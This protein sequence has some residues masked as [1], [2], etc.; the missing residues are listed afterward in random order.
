MEAFPKDKH[1]ITVIWE[2]VPHGYEN[3]N[4]KGYKI[5]VNKLENDTQNIK[6]VNFTEQRQGVIGG[7]E[8]N[9]TYSIRVLAY[10][11]VGDGPASEESFVRTGK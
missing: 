7:L 11:A 8:P 5:I 9:T 2:K 4:I 6:V 1:S 10:T 3:G